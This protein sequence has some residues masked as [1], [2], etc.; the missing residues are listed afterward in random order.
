MLVLLA[1]FPFLAD[2]FQNQGIAELL[3]RNPSLNSQICFSSRA[4]AAPLSAVLKRLTD[5]VIFF[6][7]HFKKEVE[8]NMFKV[9]PMDRESDT[10]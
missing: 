9:Y 7:S 3:H 8:A 2:S 6:F 1:N 10:H 4:S 5:T